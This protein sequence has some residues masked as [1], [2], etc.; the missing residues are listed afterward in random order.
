MRSIKLIQQSLWLTGAGL[1]IGY[2][3]FSFL[4]AQTIY[5]LDQITLSTTVDTTIQK[6]TVSQFDETGQL[7]HYLFTPEMR[8][9]PENNTHHLASP[10]IQ[11][12]QPGQADWKIDAHHAK[13]IHGGKEIL[14]TG[15]VNVH[16]DEKGNSLTTE[17][18]TYFSQEKLA[19][20]HSMVLFKQPGS[21]VHSQGMRAY[22][23]KKQIQLLSRPYATFNPKTT[24]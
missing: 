11:I 6:L 18:L 8:H 17:E 7:A 14:F 1:L 12:K 16:Q 2:F 23:D 19:T 24:P 5:K 3:C 9:I 20:S 4:K 10:Q 21:T 22:L 15:K 13:A